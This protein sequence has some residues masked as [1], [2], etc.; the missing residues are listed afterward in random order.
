MARGFFWSLGV[1]VILAASSSF[2]QEQVG[3]PDW[4]PH[5]VSPAYSVKAPLVRVDE[6]HG[7]VQTIDGRYAGFAALLRADGY[8]VDA[9]RGRLDAPGAFD[10]VG[11]LIISNACARRGGSCQPTF[12]EAEI[13][14]ISHWVEQGGSLLLVADHTPYGAAVEALAARFGVKMG[15]GYAFQLAGSRSLTTNLEYPS[16]A[17]A[18]HSIIQGRSP[19]ERV[20]LV[21]TFTGQSLDGPVGSVVLLATSVDA[22]EAADLPTLQQIQ[23]RLRNGEVADEVVTALARPALSAQG[24]AFTHGSGRVVVLGEAAMLTAQVLR[25][26]EP[27]DTE[28]LHFG[29]NTSGHDDQQFALNLMHWLS[30]LLP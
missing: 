23:Q 1:A 25:P 9:G 5:V 28:P 22:Y 20:R 19:S 14:G 24:V 26:V 8:R 4:R 30:R 16:E 2:A 13:A 21:K 7:S 29:L 15:K 3:D 18:D 11:V 10:G 12:D 17:L 27:S 6:G